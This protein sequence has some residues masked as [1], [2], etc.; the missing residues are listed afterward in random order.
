MEDGMKTLTTVM[1]L[2]A[3]SLA[4]DAR[5]QRFDT[6][7]QLGLLNRNKADLGSYDNWYSVAAIDG[8]VGRYWSPHVKTEF[9][10][11]ASGEGSIFAGYREHTVRD[12]TIGATVLYQF[13]ENQWVHPFAGG[14]LELVHERE[15]ADAFPP[16]TFRGATGA[17]FPVVPSLP[18]IDAVTYSVRPI[19]T[20]GFK[21]YVTP[22]SFIRVDA[23]TALSAERPLALQW[24]GGIGF[25]F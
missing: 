7:A 20:G 18:A 12:T 4:V 13:F 5:A 24:R 23:R 2:A 19:V 11:G 16:P 17:G 21:F 3:L 10:I 8:T 6:A 22:H 1:C 9:D 15:R 25:D 14:G